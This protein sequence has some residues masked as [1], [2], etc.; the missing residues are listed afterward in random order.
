M[1]DKSVD[2]ATLSGDTCYDKPTA[3]SEDLK[4]LKKHGV[5]K[6]RI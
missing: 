6:E 2:D 4:R 5:K 1:A 3:D